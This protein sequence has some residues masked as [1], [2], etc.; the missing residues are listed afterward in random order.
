M[1]TKKNISIN[2]TV[3]LPLNVGK[4]AIIILDEHY[5]R[6]SRVVDI[7]QVSFDK[8]QFETLNTIYSVLPAASHSDV[9]TEVQ[10]HG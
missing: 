1:S 2:G 4:P 8:I 5:L 3:Q 7:R 6:T 10:A 9:Q